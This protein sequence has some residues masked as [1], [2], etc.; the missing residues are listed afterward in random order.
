[1]TRTKR[2]ADRVARHLEG[3]GIGVAAI[4]GGKSQP[5]R[6]RALDAFSAAKVRVLVATDIAARGIDIDRVSHVVNYELPDVPEAYVH[7]IGRTARAGAA[8]IAI[9]LCDAEERGQLRDI[10]RLTG[11]SI[12]AEDR[13]QRTGAGHVER[14]A[15]HNC[16]VARRGNGARSDAAPG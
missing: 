1:F 10:E 13:R 9:S 3:A 11:L 6:E 2:R 7:R 8:G 12:P 4:H 15:R 5:Q 14:A 16:D